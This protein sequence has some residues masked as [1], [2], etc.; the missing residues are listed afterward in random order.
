MD[1]R[2]EIVVTFEELKKVKIHFFAD[3]EYF[4]EKYLLHK[5]ADAGAPIKKR[6]FAPPIIERGQV[7]RMDLPEQDA[8]KIVWE[9]D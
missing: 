2:I 1:S 9:D 6:W 7:Y 3:I 8:V 4:W 5:L